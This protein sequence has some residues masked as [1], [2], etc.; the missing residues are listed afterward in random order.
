MLKQ[1]IHQRS[2]FQN[3]LLHTSSAKLKKR[4]YETDIDSSQ[5]GFTCIFPLNLPRCNNCAS[6]FGFKVPSKVFDGEVKCC[7]KE[8]TELAKVELDDLSE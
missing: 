2:L 7:E 3:A 1:C 4:K 8:A 6:L 5:S